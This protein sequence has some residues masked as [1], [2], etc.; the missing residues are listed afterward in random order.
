MANN[1]RIYTKRNLRKNWFEN[2][3]SSLSVTNWIILVNVIVFVVLSV[4]LLINQNSIKY[5]AIQPNFIF[6]GKY[7]WTFV[8]SM[9]SHTWLFHLFANMITL[10]FIGS[11]VER[12][13]G[14]KRYL[15]FYLI[16]GLIASVFFV[17]FAYFFG[18]TNPES[19]GFGLFG[20]PEIFALGASGAIFGLAGVIT[21]LV[22]RLKVLVFFIIP[23]RM[24]AAMVFFLV[25]FWALSAFYGLPIGNSAHF[26]GFICGLI[27]GGYLR[28]KYKRKIVRLNQMVGA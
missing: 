21:M 11:F 20:S 27:Y 22:P 13:I 23:M 28:K 5:F 2:F 17:V 14:R 12:I 24:W 8:T 3:F 26:G 6:Q 16:S 15:W 1:I 19:L 25:V 4:L 7:F 18:S 10:M 9:F